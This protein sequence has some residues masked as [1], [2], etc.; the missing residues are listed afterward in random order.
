[1]AAVTPH[2]RASLAAPQLLPFLSVHQAS[3]D[4]KGPTLP[5]GHSPAKV[6]PRAHFRGA[7]G[8]QVS[9]SFRK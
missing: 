7:G 3:Q 9:S 5:P 8:K 2:S 1:M 6:P 4:H